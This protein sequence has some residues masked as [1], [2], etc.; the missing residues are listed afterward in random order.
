MDGLYNAKTTIHFHD[1]LPPVINHRGAARIARIAAKKIVGKDGVVKQLHPSLGGEDFAY[2]LQ[3]VPG[4][5]VRFGAGHPELPNIPAHSP[6]FNF[7]E[8]VLPVGA[9]FLAQVAWQ[10]LQLKLEFGTL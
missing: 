8:G 6:Y 9:A 5:L 3:K 2:Y 10:T 4:C 1:G 7:D